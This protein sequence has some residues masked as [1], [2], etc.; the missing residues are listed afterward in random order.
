MKK[1]LILLLNLFLISSCT[2]E[3][4]EPVSNSSKNII[5]KSDPI[6]NNLKKVINSESDPLA[7]EVCV[8]FIYP[9]TLLIYNQNLEVTNTHILTGD[10]MFI[11]VI[12]NLNNNQSISISY[13]IQTTLPDGTL[14]SVN[15]NEELKN[16]L[17]FCSLEDIINHCNGTFSNS[18]NS[19]YTC[20]FVPFIEGE[21]NTFAGAKFS[22]NANG[23]LNIYHLNNNYTGT[24]S[25]INI[26]DKIYL[27]LHILEN[28]DI[29]SAWNSNFEIITLT[30]ENISIKANNIIKKL[31]KFRGVNQ[32]YSIGNPG[33]KN[34]IVAYDKGSYSDGWRYIEVAD[35]NLPLTEWGCTNLGIEN[36]EFSTIGSGLQ[37]NYAILNSHNNLTN[38]YTN[39]SICSSSNNGTVVS[40]NIIN[41]FYNNSKEWFIPSYEELELIYNNISTPQFM[42]FPNS[43]YWSSTEIDFTKVKVINLQTGTTSIVSKNNH[44]IKTITIRYF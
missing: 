23:S 34:G 8:D 17:D 21:N 10:D 9:F 39:P 1:Y 35:R 24:W 44:T 32:T 13:P 16:A 3:K 28:S 20:W 40:K 33:P 36:A 18:N 41:Q 27:N 38:Y 12:N 7:E 5:R 4:F 26:G 2:N 29:A 14:F 15:N 30:D 25:F 19:L 42:T 31:E 43:F 11:N 22:S 37:N 6:F